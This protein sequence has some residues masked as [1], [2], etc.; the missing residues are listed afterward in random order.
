VSWSCWESIWVSEEVG[1]DGDWVS[2]YCGGR[3]STSDECGSLPEVSTNGVEINHSFAK[4]YIFFFMVGEL[5]C[6]KSS[7][8]MMGAYAALY[9]VHGIPTKQE[10]EER[11][12]I[13]SFI[14]ATITVAEA[15]SLMT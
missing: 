7:S 1:K 11:W 6:R 2:G 14:F 10:E 3:K 4:V 15:S 12:Y 8:W 5:K 13:L 9:E